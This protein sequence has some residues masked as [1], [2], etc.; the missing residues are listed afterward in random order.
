MTI[1]TSESYT[2][3][4]EDANMRTESFQVNKGPFKN[5][6]PPKTSTKCCSLQEKN[7]KN[8]I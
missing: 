8:A 3:L 1:K 2:I 7:I 6:F 5:A 4:H